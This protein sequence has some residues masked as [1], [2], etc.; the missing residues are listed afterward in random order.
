VSQQALQDLAQS[1]ASALQ[2]GSE[3]AVSRATQRYLQQHPEMKRLA[4][5]L[6]EQGDLQGRELVMRLAESSED[7]ELLSALKSFALG[8]HGP[9]AMRHQALQVVSEAGLLPPGPVRMWLGGEWQEIIPL[10]FEIY[11]E[12]VER[13]YPKQ[14]QDWMQEAY[15]ALQ[16]GEAKKAEQLLGQA[17]A[18]TPDDPS[19][20]NNLGAAYARQGRNAEAIQIIHQLYEQH[21]DYFFGV[22][23]MANLYLKDKKLEEAETLLKPLLLQRRLHISEFRAL[24]VCQIQLSLARKR[25]EGADRWLEIW[26]DIEPDAPD[27][28][29]WEGKLRLHRLKNMSLRQVLGFGRKPRS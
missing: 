6:L 10:V 12:P 27:L 5:I 13:D 17:L 29:Y 21:P 2:R 8:Q 22:I 23:G 20:L 16:E 3:Q 1:L 24:A 28:R 25:S 9:D 19:I 14:V 15:E 18:V 11:E 26:T 4:P 7:S